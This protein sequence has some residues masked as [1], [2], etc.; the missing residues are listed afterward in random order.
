[1]RTATWTNAW[2]SSPIKSSRWPA[3]KWSALWDICNQDAK[4]SECNRCGPVAV[5]AGEDGRIVKEITLGILVVIAT[6]IIILV[7][8]RIVA[9]RR[10]EFIQQYDFPH[11]L[12]LKVQS[13]YPAISTSLLDLVAHALKQ[14]FLIAQSVPRKV[15]PMPSR[16]VDAL[17]HEF[18]LDTKAYTKF[19][20]SAFGRY[21]HHTPSS[22]S[23][24][25]AKE[26]LSLEEAMALACKLEGINLR[27]PS[28][29][30]VLFA[31]DELTKIPEGNVYQLPITLLQQGPRSRQW[32][33]GCGG[34]ACGG[35]GHNSDGGDSGCGGG[36][37]GCGGGGD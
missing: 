35:G 30:P 15:V 10:A 22:S 21:F 34:V 1:M 12:L 23:Y 32:S 13:Q 8:R 28:R 19:C 5:V 24:S 20:E 16:V 31:I 14:Y 37:G 3:S 2:L 27:H 11:Y 4:G 36:D 7:L 33:D 18:I 17:W 25:A 9:K 6:S 26:S 29:L